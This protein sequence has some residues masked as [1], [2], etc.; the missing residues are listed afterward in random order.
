MGLG[1]I[2]PSSLAMDNVDA[3][4]DMKR[5]GEKLGEQVDLRKQFAPFLK[6]FL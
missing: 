1:D 6:E 2:A 4:L 3:A 5:I